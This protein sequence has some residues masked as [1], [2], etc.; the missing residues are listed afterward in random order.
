[1]TL[2][3][4]RSSPNLDASK[5]EAAHQT[6]YQQLDAHIVSLRAR[7]REVEVMLSDER[8]QKI[9]GDNKYEARLLTFAQK[10]QEKKKE[11]EASQRVVAEQ[12]QQIVKLQGAQQHTDG[13]GQRAEEL[14]QLLE[15]QLE[16]KN[17]QNLLLRDELEKTGAQVQALQAELAAKVKAFHDQLVKNNELLAQAGTALQ[18]RVVVHRAPP[19]P[20]SLGVLLHGLLGLIFCQPTKK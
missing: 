15:T 9:E 12:F 4:S 7:I 13:E 20:T 3:V 18:Q 6:R 16:E 11:L 8:V 2:L 5:L 19:A 10:L 1:M 14:I 17:K